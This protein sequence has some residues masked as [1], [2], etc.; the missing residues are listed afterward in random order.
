[1]RLSDAPA[2]I[3]QEGRVQAFLEKAGKFG[4]PATVVYCRTDVLPVRCRQG[5]A[6]HCAVGVGHLSGRFKK[7]GAL[8]G[9]ECVQVC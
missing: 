4:R 5:P 8:L 9:M 3:C 1:M 2:N 6:H 7:L